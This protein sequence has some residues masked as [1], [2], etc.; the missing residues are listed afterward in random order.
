V[1]ESLL[2]YDSSCLNALRLFGLCCPDQVAGQ[3]AGTDVSSVEGKFRL[4][5]GTSKV[6]DELEE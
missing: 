4:L 1:A 2:T 5:E 3:L 6:D